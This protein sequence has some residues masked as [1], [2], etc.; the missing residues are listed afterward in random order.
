MNIKEALVEKVRQSLHGHLQ[1]P[2]ISLVPDE[3]FGV[4]VRVISP[5]FEH[6]D[7]YD[8]QKLVWGRLLE[9]L[10]RLERRRLE[11]VFTNSPSEMEARRLAA[12]VDSSPAR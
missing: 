9:D 2:D 11:F 7:D 10:N 4:L 5:T 6:M 12:R 3:E 1:D 8:R